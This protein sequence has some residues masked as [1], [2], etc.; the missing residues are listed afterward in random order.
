MTTA[1]RTNHA[2]GS[3]QGLT[4]LEQRFRFAGDGARAIAIARLL[5]TARLTG[6]DS[7]FG[8]RPGDEGARTESSWTLRRFSPA[9]GH[10]FDVH[11]TQQDDST[12]LVRFSQPDRAAV[13]RG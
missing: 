13:P 9:P 10:R 12:F 11:L 4:T 5:L 8:A 6:A 1:V 2:L 7:V 3:R